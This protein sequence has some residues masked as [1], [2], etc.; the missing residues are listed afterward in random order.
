MAAAE[1]KK[2]FWAPREIAL[3]AILFGVAI[4]V[5]RDAFADIW[6]VGISHPDQTHILLVPFVAAW[7]LWVRRSRLRYLGYHPSLLGPVVIAIGWVMAWAGYETDIRVAWHVGAIMTV[8]G[9]V[10]SVVGKAALRQFLPVIGVLIFLVPVPAF[11]RTELAV[12]L[13]N[14][15]TAT[16][17][18]FLDLFGIL[19]TREGNVIVIKGQQV[20]VG[21]ACN[22]M[23]MVFSLT[24]VVYAFVFSIS[25][26][27]TTRLVLLALSPVIALVCNVIRLIPTSLVYGYGTTEAAESLHNWAGWVMLPIA[28]LI[29]MAILRVFHWLEL[30]TKT[31]RLAETAP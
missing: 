11:V 18:F 10:L 29:M 7:L 13:Q 12:P 3:A 30:P 26:K 15:A 31:W 22:G 16:T 2:R 28:V 21:E 6:R 5:G 8:V 20:A 24:L 1:I 9:A 23:R 27:P 4:W 19:S 25:F 17:H 14:M